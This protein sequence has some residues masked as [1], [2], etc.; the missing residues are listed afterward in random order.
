MHS[1][2]TEDRTAWGG[3]IGAQYPGLRPRN[4]LDNLNNKS[5][6]REHIELNIVVFGCKLGPLNW[7]CVWWMS[8]EFPLILYEVDKVTDT[9]FDADIVD[10]QSHLRECP[11]V[12]D[13]GRVPRRSS[14]TNGK[15]LSV[16]SSPG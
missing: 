9:L 6:V 1:H 16:Q 13:I 5:F 14:F 8:M 3:I 7:F 2:C 11:D 12:E 4:G 15:I 10:Q